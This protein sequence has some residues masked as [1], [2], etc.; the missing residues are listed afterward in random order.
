M[1]IWI[2]DADRAI[3]E[4]SRSIR[5]SPV[6]PAIGYSLN[7]L[8]HAFLPKN[9]AEKAIDYACRSTHEMPRWTSAWMA[10]VVASVNVGNEQEAQEA[11]RRMLTL[12]PNFSITKRWNLFRDKREFYLISDGLHK[13]GLPE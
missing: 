4:F 11:A 10:L 5:L 6:D 7:G 13:A 12:S 2:S 9:E 8:A 3:D 1:R